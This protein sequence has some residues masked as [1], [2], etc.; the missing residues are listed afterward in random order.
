MGDQPWWNV[1][2]R[3]FPVL[4]QIDLL[5]PTHLDNVVAKTSRGKRLPKMAQLIGL[6]PNATSLHS[7]CLWSLVSQ[8]RG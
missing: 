8:E 3:P 7:E 6:T 1:A 5:D 2:N 4:S